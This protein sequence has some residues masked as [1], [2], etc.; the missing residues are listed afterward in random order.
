MKTLTFKKCDHIFYIMSKSCQNEQFPLFFFNPRDLRHNYC[1]T[2]MMMKTIH[3]AIVTMIMITIIIWLILVYTTHVYSA[4]CTGLL[5]RLW[6]IIKTSTIHLW[7]A[8][9]TKL[10]TNNVIFDQFFGILIEINW[11]F[12]FLC[13][14]CDKTFKFNINWWKFVSGKWQIS[15]LFGK[16][17]L[18]G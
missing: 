5:T 8:E 7:A 4:F 13:N 3:L 2:I 10:R 12:W 1:I 11:F 16:T 17:L 6:V 14:N 9:E 18:K 15:W